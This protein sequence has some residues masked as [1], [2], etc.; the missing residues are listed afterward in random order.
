MKRIQA[1]TW[2]ENDRVPH[3]VTLLRSG[4]SAMDATGQPAA[5]IQPDPNALVVELWCRD[6]TLADLEAHRDYGPAAILF[7]AEYGQ[8]LPTDKLDSAAFSALGAY[9]TGLGFSSAWVANT[10]GLSADAFTRVE[11]AGKLCAEMQRL[12]ATSVAQL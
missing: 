8:T 5:N 10:I 2:W 9:L 11:L 6:E 3:I 4:D 1:I 12:P 7:S